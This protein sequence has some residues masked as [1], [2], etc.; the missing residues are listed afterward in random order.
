MRFWLGMVGFMILDRVG[1][2]AADPVAV[3]DAR[4]NF[5]GACG[6]WYP[7]LLTLHRF[8]IAIF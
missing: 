1:N 4:R 2:S 8:F 3:I 7:V 5:A 6:R